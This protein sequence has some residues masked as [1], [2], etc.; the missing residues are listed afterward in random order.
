MS[1]SEN[2]VDYRLNHIWK[3]IKRRCYNQNFKQYKDYGG[4]GISVCDEWINSEKIS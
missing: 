1:R 4:R 3:D 2:W